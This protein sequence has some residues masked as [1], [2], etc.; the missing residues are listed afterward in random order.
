MDDVQL[1]KKEANETPFRIDDNHHCRNEGRAFQSKMMNELGD[2]TV[3]QQHVKRTRD[4]VIKHP[5]SMLEKGGGN[6]GNE[7]LGVSAMKRGRKTEIREVSGLKGEHNFNRIGTDDLTAGKGRKCGGSDGEDGSVVSQRGPK[8]RGRKRTKGS[9]VATVS[10]NGYDEGTFNGIENKSDAN[11]RR[12]KRSCTV[13]SLNQREEETPTKDAKKKGDSTMCHQCQRNDKGRVVR[14]TSCGRKR[15]CLPCL[16]TW[17]PQASEESI[18]EACPVCRENCNCK[19][20]LRLDVPLKNLDSSKLEV[21]ENEKFQHSK[22]LLQILL[23]YL[24]RFNQEQQM[25]KER[26]AKMQGLSLAEIKVQM[27]ICDNDERVYCNNCRTS[28]VDFHRSCPDCSYDLCLTCCEEIRDGNPQGNVKELF[29]EYI[30]RGPEYLHGKDCSHMS[31][32]G[33][34]VSSDAHVAKESP[35][36]EWKVNENGSIPCPPESLGGCSRGP[37][38]LRSILAE[39]WVLE[40]LK[41][42]EEIAKIYNLTDA[43]ELM[44]MSNSN[45]CTCSNNGNDEVGKRKA[46]AREDSND[47]YL[48]SPEGRDI[49]SEDLKHFQWHWIRGE[50][51]IVGNV[52]ETTSGLSWE[53][54]VMWRAFRQITNTK[55]SQ[56]LEVKAIDCLDWSEL[57]V[58]IHQFFKGYSEG[59]FDSYMWPQILKL[60]DWP[61]ANL[62]EEKLPRHGAEFICALPFK[63]YTH[64][65]SGYLNLFVK[66][67]DGSLKPDMGPKSYIAYGVAQELGRGDSVTKLHCDMS[68]AVNVLTHTAEVFLTSKQ[69]AN[70]DKLKQQHMA[71]DRIELYNISQPEFPEVKKDLSQPDVSSLEI[72]Q[73]QSQIFMPEEVLAAGI[74][75]ETKPLNENGKSD[76]VVSKKADAKSES[77]LFFEEKISNDVSDEN[78]KGLKRKKGRRRR[79]NFSASKRIKMVEDESSCIPLEVTTEGSTQHRAEASEKTEDTKVNVDQISAISGSM[80]DGG[81][82]WDIFRRQDVP[83]LQEYLKNHFKEFRHIHC[84]PLQQVIHPIHDQIFYLTQEHKRK[85]KEEYGIEPWTFIQ[86]LGDAV[87]IPA[88]CPHQVRN[89]KSCIKVAMDFVSP[90]NVSECVR[91]TEEFRKLPSNHL[92]KEDKVEVKKMTLHG[93]SQAV[94]VLK[95]LTCST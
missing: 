37:L 54:M 39:N 40:L 74:K 76:D 83:K 33:N 88:G 78:G 27:A 50:P 65:R 26:E 62:F 73:S 82:V 71:Q 95:A 81:A 12:S 67:P 23:P 45:R 79:A 43:N 20:C 25:E 69:L 64:P 8:K 36:S 22:Y 1:M 75:A 80:S 24:K 49:G 3:S 34:N 56:Q 2:Q 51:V 86:K 19:A 59:R 92:A 91:L 10:T 89:L 38:E 21:S 84:A 5:G 66:L 87:F 52:L 4:D 17:Y 28:I 72:V 15:Y 11:G 70:I 41:E 68:D 16:Q 35:M 9:A 63:E 90:E 18:A 94:K 44:T 14:C 61:P 29:I 30:D 53:P 93:I 32:S 42:A 6:V 55:H 58:N 47:N 77:G 7:E 48:Y 57:E 46:A 85:L 13:R 60:K 31:P